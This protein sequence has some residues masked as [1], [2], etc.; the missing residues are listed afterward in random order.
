MKIS[1][2]IKNKIIELYCNSGKRIIKIYQEVALNEEITFEEFYSI[3][4]EYNEKN[5]GNLKRTKKE[6]SEDEVLELLQKGLTQTE[7]GK[8]LGVSDNTISNRIKKM[9]K[10]GVEIPERKKTERKKTER[11]KENDEKDNKILEMLEEGLT[12]TEIGKQLGIS[13]TAISNRIRKMRKRGVEIPERK[14]EN[15]EKD[16]KILG[17]LEK[18]LTQT[19]IGKQLGVTGPTISDRIKKMRKRGVEIP[20]KKKT[21]DTIAKNIVN[22]INSKN[23]SIEQVRNMAKLYG[24]D[25]KV[26][27]LL[28]ALD[29]Q[30]R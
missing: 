12:Q 9:R 18:G 2:E 3:L 10:R 26:E 29:E 24:V 1:E 5:S 28:K 17:M 16:N 6:F 21:T 4:K 11:K 14:K 19:E 25:E 22:L 7:I 27:E 20:E 15:D 8:Q 30:E 13:H 23:A